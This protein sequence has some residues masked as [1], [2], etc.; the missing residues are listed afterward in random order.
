MN[1]EDR[2]EEYRQIMAAMMKEKLDK[3]K[4]HPARYRPDL[5]MTLE[6]WKQKEY[7]N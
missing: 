6:F 4:L 2:K 3:M 7:Q 5:G 1:D